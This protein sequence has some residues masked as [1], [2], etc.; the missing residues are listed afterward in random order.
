MTWASTIAGSITTPNQSSRY[1]RKITGWIIHHNAALG[2][3]GV[4]EMMRTGSKQVSA[5][6]QV[7]QDGDVWGVV[8]RENRSWSA[9]NADWDAASLTFEIANDSLA[10]GW[11]ISDRA[12][13]RVARTIAEDARWAGIPINRQTV[14]GHRE[15]S[16]LGDGGSYSTACP[17]G[18]DLD[19]LVG[20]AQKFSGSSLAGGDPSSIEE[21][22]MP[23]L[24]RHPNGSIGFVSDAGELDAISTLNEV[25]SLK[26]VGLVGNWV[27]LPDK[28]IWDTLTARTAR[29]RA[30]RATPG[31][32][33][34]EAAIV[35]GIAP[36]LIPAVV[37]ALKGVGSGLT[38][39]QV[40]AATEAAVRAVFA[41]AAS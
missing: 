29:L 39:E 15:G 32:D 5:N 16:A 28:N 12:Y 6:Y 36:L 38:A 3:A 11:T 17:G 20:L 37:E 27:Q 21:I 4:L 9:S 26:A 13:E 22:P 40:K 30:Q 18:I 31:A 24:I 8:P 7:M 1:G 25:E 10:P 23:A 19:R 35:A 41:D 14:R 33:V 2:G 34:D